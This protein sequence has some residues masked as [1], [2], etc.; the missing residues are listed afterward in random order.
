MVTRLFDS[1]RSGRP[2]GFLRRALLC[3]LCALVGL[4]ACAQF[5]TASLGGTVLDSSGA[6]L[7]DTRVSVRNVDTGFTQTVAADPSGAFLFSRLPVG[8]YELRA[9]RA[10]FNTYVQKGL[11]LTVDRAAT[12][13][14][15]LE[16]GQLT[17]Q[18]TV[19]ADAELVAT[20]TGTVA[21][22]IDQK[23]IVELPLNGRM[24]QTLVFVSAGTVDLGRN[25]CRICG[26][27]G[28]YPG[29][30]TA[31]VN[32]AGM[33]Q[34]NYQLDGTGHNDTYLNASVPFP[35]P[36]AVQEF[37]LQAS[38]FTAEYGNAGGGVVNIVTK[39]GTN[40]LHG[41]LFEF[42]RNGKLNARN[43]FAPRQD[44]LKRNQF[45]GSLGGPMV[46][47]KLFYF[48]TYQGTRVRSEAAGRVAFVPTPAER[49]GDFSALGRPI[50]DPVT[51]QPIPNNRIPAASISPAANFFLKSI[52]SPNRAGRELN[53]VGTP[54]VQTENQ[55]M[56]KADYNLKKHQFNG[57]YFFT[58]FSQPAVIPRE[59]VLAAA[60]TGN[61]VRVQNVSVNHV[62]TFSPT[63]LLNSTFG[64]NRQRG[65]SLSSAPFSF[66]DAGV[67]IASAAQSALKAPPEL[68]LSVTG[69]FSISTNHLG[70]FDR[71]DFTIRENLTKVHSGHEL[72]FG[73]EAVRL[74]NH[75]TKTYRMDGNFT[76]NGSLSGDGLADF[77][78]GR[79][80][81]FVQG[82]GEFK[83]LRGTRWGFFA[84][85]NWR[86]S[87]RLTLNLGL[88]WDPYWPY[89]DREGRVICFQ[90]GAKSK[91]YPN[92]PAGMLYGG[93]NHDSG[94]PT[95]GSDP[96]IWNLAP[97]LGFA[98]RLTKDGKTSIR[99]GVGY[100]FTPIQA[101][102]YN[103]F[104]NI[105]P[106]AP[107]F[108]FDGVA[109]ADPYG[110][111]GVTNPFPAQYGPRVP[112]PEATFVTPTELRAVF[113]PNFRTPLLTTWNLSVERQVGADWVF[114]AGYVGNKGT[115]MF[116][117]AE[118]S[119]EINPAIYAPG[120]STVA[121]TQARRY[122]QDYS[123]IGFYESG[124]NSNYHS[125]QLNAEKRFA[126]GLSVLANYTW[127]KKFDDYGW[128]TPDNRR[129]DYG[130][131]R[132]D[133]PHNFK[134]SNVWD[135]PHLP[136][137]GA[138]GKILNG[139][140][141]N[142]LVTWQSG[143]PFTAT[144]GRD[145]SFTGIGR[146]RADFVGGSAD[147]GSGRAH[148]ELIARYFDISKFAPNALGT[149]G[150][151]GKYNLRAPRYFNTDFGVLKSTRVTERIAVQFRGEF[152]NIFNNVVFNGPT[153]NQSSAQFGRITSSLDPRII[154]FGMKLLF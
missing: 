101:S 74:S 97:R 81:T 21:Q 4:P 37:N 91:R 94:C 11:A 130:I 110:S 71:G 121:N 114:R 5:T 30:Q 9:E 62:Y 78:M 17:Q 22:L 45:G 53:F 51:R 98:Y 129:F 18:V 12:Q 23:R 70:D 90:P 54:T 148:G 146:D 83:I 35:N 132:E 150:S 13:T 2:T 56:T 26:H 8:N 48:G 34:V 69:A 153:S 142:S 134:F 58:D 65:G 136:V 124:N 115:W 89:Y 113:D 36:D 92:A 55:F 116:A 154:Q 139:W 15:T 88:R 72:H 19:E 43:F 28:V 66:P 126:K 105:A 77:L 14:I 123:R 57:R 33:A 59:N 151:S 20:R 6:A 99:G 50:V 141:L 133:V 52:P 46:K 131:S 44:T 67:K 10:G 147:L 107:G 49:V 79:S 82:G 80:S 1:F 75:I 104:T 127:S 137:R 111:A 60:N 138:A 122:Y 47:N 86:V 84:Q 118:N 25:G 143:F 95:G 68:V 108:S 102:T 73:G 40:E 7:P 64:L 31:G 3:A 76:F 87:Q 112:G 119:R 106:F 96:N 149:F 100:F 16:V 42:L 32:G 117:A 109:F 24:A 39:S 135:I 140:M 27:G 63:M 120:R 85:D 152:F 29:E 144:S 145:N 125:L 93:D 128:T 38:N 41:S 103:P 61:R